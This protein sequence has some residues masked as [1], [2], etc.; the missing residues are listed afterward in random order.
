MVERILDFISQLT[1]SWIYIIIFAASYLENIF[2]PLPSDLVIVVAGSLIGLGVLHF[3][4][5]LFLATIG[6]VIGFMT[7]FYI[8][9]VTDKKVVHS[10]K[11][12][13]ISVE[14]IE[15]AEHWFQKYG[16][17]VILTNRFLPGARTIIS[18]FG[19]LSELKKIKTA[20]LATVSALVWNSVMIYLGLMF[21]SNV[22]S[23]D[24]YLSTYSYLVYLICAAL[25][26]FFILRFFLR[27]KNS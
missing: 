22:Q 9:T 1:P 2:P 24:Y 5:T 6:S 15:N 7:L 20:V 21:G 23:V 25:L 18:F 27:K 19:G 3:I 17:W 16:Y 10:G 11:I 26:I 12:R 4:P 14:S 8:G 13:F